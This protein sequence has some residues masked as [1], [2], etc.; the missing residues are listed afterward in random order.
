[1]FGSIIFDKCI[2]E[3][4]NFIKYLGE[5]VKLLDER[6]IYLNIKINFSDYF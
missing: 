5:I 1:M 3:L 2:S 6:N 4:F